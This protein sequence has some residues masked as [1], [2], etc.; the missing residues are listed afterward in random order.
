MSPYVKAAFSG[1]I[2]LL[3][4]LS[5]GLSIDGSLTLAT[6]LAAV[7]AGLVAAGGV[8]NIPYTPKIKGDHEA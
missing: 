6:W 2:A 3:G 5:G 7:T 1:L 8:Y 4:T